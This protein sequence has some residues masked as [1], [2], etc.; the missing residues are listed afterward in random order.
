MH[1]VE[2]HFVPAVS[3]PS[4]IAMVAC[5]FGQVRSGSVARKAFQACEWFRLAIKS[6]DAAN[7]MRQKSDTQRTKRQPSLSGLFKPTEPSSQT[8]LQ[9]EKTKMLCLMRAGSHLLYRPLSHF[10]P[11]PL[12]GKFNHQRMAKM[13]PVS[14]AP[15]MCQGSRRGTVK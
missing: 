1:V 5:S 10:P 2:K 11:G 15:I 12:S 9:R 7:P 6:H 14:F 8:Q 3:L 4:T 13:L